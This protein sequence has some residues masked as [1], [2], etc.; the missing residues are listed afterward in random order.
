MRLGV[1]DMLPSDF[2][3]YT[4]AQMQA[5][6]ALGFTGFGCHLDGRL[7]PAIT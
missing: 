6:A 3:S 2:R 5:I 4:P 1:V 7:A